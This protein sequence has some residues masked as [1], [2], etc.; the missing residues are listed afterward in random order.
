MPQERNRRYPGPA[1]AG[2]ALLLAAGCVAPGEDL[3]TIEQD[4]HSLPPAA[5]RLTGPLFWLHGDESQERLEEIL[6]KVAEGGNGCFTAESRP[7]AD[8]LGPGWFRD[9]EVCLAAAKRLDIEMWIFDERWWPSGEVAG[10]VPEEHGSRWL[11]AAAETVAGSARVERAVDEAHLVAVLAGRGGADGID[12]ESLVDLT[13]LVA[14]G[15]LA[16]RA[17]AGDWQL[18]TFTWRRDEGRQG[19]L[20]VDGASQAAVDWYLQTVYEPHYER[21]AA[22][23]GRTIRGFFYDEPETPG[24]WGTEVI[25]VLV[26]QGVDW[27]KALVAWKLTLAGEEQAA[28]RYWYR[29]AFAEAWGRTLFGGIERW[30]RERGVESI[31]HFLEHAEGFLALELCAGDMVQLQK[32]S[33]LGGIDAVFA[34][35]VMGSREGQDA[36]TWQTPKLGSSISH[37]YG[38]RDDRAMVEIFGA[39]GQDLTYRE[40]KWWTDH[41]QVSGINFHIPHSFNPRAPFDRDCPPYFYNGGCEPRWPLY[42]VYADYTTR[43]SLLLT[44]GRHVCPVA[45]LYLGQCR[46]EED[47]RP[48]VRFDRAGRGD[49]ATS[50]DSFKDTFSRATRSLGMAA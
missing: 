39:R 41:M 50:L 5:R 31:G 21:F 1:S 48:V 26:E 8:W 7:H 32:H 35:F 17:P 27:K 15:R 46:H 3:A 34:Q 38:K 4:F 37:A 25:P 6:A 45:F 14:D 44:E 40:M 43:L 23:F 11:E 22:D 49:H 18:L 13:G 2:A 20:L 19:G 28:A 33:S 36:P 10:R 16:W 29:W 24:D 42:R 9:L 47:V 12:G 30:C